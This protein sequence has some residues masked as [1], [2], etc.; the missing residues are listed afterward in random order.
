MILVSNK[1]HKI[2][3]HE[4]SREEGI[5]MTR[6]LGC[7]FIECSSKT[8]VNIEKAFCTVIRM[9][10]HNKRCIKCG[11]NSQLCKSWQISLKKITTCCENLKID[12]LIR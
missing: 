8:N 5:N 2:T 9:I 6:K 4:V 7:E 10:C 3:E 12:N 11:K 1:Y